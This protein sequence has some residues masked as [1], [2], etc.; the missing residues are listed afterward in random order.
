MD[1]ER[2]QGVLDVVSGLSGDFPLRVL[3]GSK[4]TSAQDF[5]ERFT[6]ST[7]LSFSPRS[8]RG[9]RLALLDEADAMIVVRTGISES[10]AFEIAYNVFVLGLPMFIAVHSSAPIQTTL[11][12]DLDEISPTTYASFDE[13]ADLKEPLTAFLS[14]V[15]VR[16][17][18]AP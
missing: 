18:S 3:T 1:R 9:H 15:S 16:E 2:V 11:L 12:R 4:A 13:P 10:G 8:F 17:A 6:E 5:R 7:G 14:G